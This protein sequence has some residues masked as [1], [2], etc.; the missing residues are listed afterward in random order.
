MKSRRCRIADRN[1]ADEPAAG[2]GPAARGV[3]NRR[4]DPGTL[5]HPDVR[6]YS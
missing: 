6:G 5:D 3:R 4:A 1:E 2:R